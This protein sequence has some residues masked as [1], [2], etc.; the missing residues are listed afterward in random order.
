MAVLGAGLGGLS[1][2]RDL[3][4]AGADVMV[5]EARDRPGGRVEAVTLPDGRTVQAGGEVFGHG[6]TAYR[7]LV[8]ELGL[9]LI[10]SYVADPGQMSWGL[11]AGVHIGDEPPWFTPEEHADAAR[12]DQAFATLAQG[13]DPQGPWSH[14]DA[15]A[16][17]AISVGAWLREIEALP[18]VRRRHEIASLSLSC[19]SPERTSLLAELRKHAV[20]GGDG[21]YDL[22]RWEGLKVAEGSAAVPLAMARELAGRIRFGTVVEWIQVNPG[23][24]RITLA[25][26]ELIEAEAVVCAIPTSPLRDVIITGLSDARLQSLRSQRNALAAK[27]VVAYEESFW[28]AN[29]Q[30]GLAESEW[31][32]GS[33]WPQS[34]GV[35]SLLVPPERFAA[36]LAAPPDARAE[37]VL[38]G[39]RALYGELAAAPLAML[40]RLWGTDPFTRGYIAS[41]APGDVSRV[42]PLHGTHEPPFY[43]AGSDHW[44]AGYMEGA[45][46]TGRDAARAALRLEPPQ[47]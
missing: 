28:Q 4:R 8:G 42:G 45:V 25:G 5:L 10:P 7:E 40:E 43:V 36:Y 6:H 18:A 38:D 19:D 9:T 2:A 37:V 35:L 29:G 16:L 3:V 24:V 26:G 34:P 1:A 17:D 15:A 22:E 33:T 12:V 21:F 31:L 41:W 23:G 13:V 44:V 47:S 32:F 46:A 20:L 27:V 14:P 39:L 11:V 30:N